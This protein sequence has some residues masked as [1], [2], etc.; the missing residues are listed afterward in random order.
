MNF[1]KKVLAIS[2]ASIIGLA[3]CND[4]TK[5][6]TVVETP[7]VTPN[8][9]ELSLLGRYESGIFAES[10]AEI[11]AFDP[12]SKRIFTVNAKKGL[13]DV[14]DGSDLSQPK[15]IGELS[16]QSIL[17]D[18]E[19][20]SVAVHNGIVALAV[21]APKK[22]DAG[23]VAFFNAKDLSYI[24][25]VTVGAL[26]DMV[27]FSPDGKH[28]LVANE[29]EPEAGYQIDPEG[30]IAVI[31]V[32]TINK[33]VVRIADFSAFNDKKAQLIAEGVRIYGPNATVAQDL[34]P[35]Y[36]TISAD[37]KTAWA[38]LQE[39]NALAQID[40]ATATVTHIYPLGFKHHG[41]AGNG[42]DVSDKD[43]KININTWQGLYGVYQPD[44][45]ANYQVD[46]ETYLVTANEGDA[47]EW[48]SDEKAY[49][50][51]D[52]SKGFMEEFRVKHLVHDKGFARRLGD[53]L[54]AQLGQ[55]AKGGRL[56]PAI[57]AYCGASATSSGDCS[58]DENLGRLNIIWNMGYQ[59][60]SDG[61]AKL[62]QDGY[63]VYDKLFSFGTRS[64]SI[65]S[66]SGQ[67]V[68]DSADQLEQQIA[69]DLPDYFNSNHEAVAFDDRSDNKGPEPEGLALGTIGQKTFA[70]VGL[71][72]VGGIMVYN[73][74]QPK[75]PIFVQY[76]N[77]RDFSITDPSKDL[78]KAG[79]L[80]P[81][82]LTFIAAKNS[83]TG[84]PIL[85]VGNEVSGTTA[86]YRINLK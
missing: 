61:S 71:E 54:P 66:S 67:L 1:S 74:S 9:I 2:L 50:A 28:V 43:D 38:T 70:F 14:L 60:N 72:R 63:L 34:E 35:E 8:S 3:A 85:L 46:G 24:S 4:H 15:H 6:E 56:N 25:H 44:S 37:S 62:D 13:V 17:A 39:N 47:R 48:I 11:T 31:D 33:P 20:N 86:I 32:S 36:I 52:E 80:G 40:I 29:G 59:T 19:V 42:L 22:T 27:T 58:K 57:F 69:K 7:E 55:L 23:F 68:W 21:Q 18:T 73:I 53:D 51:G 75:A 64:F 81:E 49:Y 16:A 45:I 76:I 65:W 78:S 30:S 83:P 5:D 41:L 10:A 12:E 84:T 77:T 79:D 82:G 26:P